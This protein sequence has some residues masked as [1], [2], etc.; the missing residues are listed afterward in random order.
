M[1]RIRQHMTLYFIASFLFRLKSYIVYRFVFYIKLDNF[2][3]ELIIF[4]NPFIVS[5]IFF[6]L[7]VWFTKG[8]NQQLFLRY[9]ALIGSIVIYVNVVF[10]R[11]FTDFI[12]IPQ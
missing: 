6:G 5:I 2:L 7:S 1:C 4:I 8:K 10:Y 11:S 9:S 12:T 3:Q